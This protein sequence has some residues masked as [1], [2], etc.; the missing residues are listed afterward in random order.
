MSNLLLTIYTHT[1]L[2]VAV[3]TRVLEP[4]GYPIQHQEEKELK[5]MNS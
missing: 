4:N 5:E 1:Q 2:H 3:R